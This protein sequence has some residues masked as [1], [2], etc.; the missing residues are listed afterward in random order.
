M[1]NDATRTKAVG[2]QIASGA[3]WLVLLRLTLRIIGFVSTA[4]LARLLVPADYGIV[5]MASSVLGALEALGT[6]GLILAL[7]R[8]QNADRSF[9]DTVWTITLAKGIITGAIIAGGAHLAATYLNEPRLEAV[10]YVLA[11]AVVIQGAE[12]VGVIEFRKDLQFDKEFQL[13][14]AGRLIAFV[15]TVGSAL[16]IWRSHWALIA[17]MV[18][19]TLTRFAMTYL[20]H[21]FRPRLSMAAW[22]KLFAFSLW[23]WLSNLASL[24]RSHGRTMVVA[25][26]LDSR[27]VGLFAVGQDIANLPTSELISAV[28]RVLYSGFAK[29]NDD[30]AALGRMVTQS[31][32]ILLLIHLPICLGLIL[33]ADPL[34]RIALGTQWLEVTPLI[35]ILAAA[36]LVGMPGPVTGMALVAAGLPHVDALRYIAYAVIE[37]PTLIMSLAYGGLAGGAWAIFAVALIEGVTALVIGGRYLHLSSRELARN[38]YRVVI[39]ATVMAGL[40]YLVGEQLGDATNLVEALIRLFVMS[41][42]GATI[43]AGLVLA[44]WMLSGRPESPE[45]QLLGLAYKRVGWLARIGPR[46]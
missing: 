29:V 32:N 43:Y 5:A 15:V 37:V 42:V 20:M 28:T 38:S 6:F 9:Y 3:A 34:V 8:Y 23:S 12:N 16:L 45:R 4:L 1:T 14:L 24:A 40:V 21:P 46:L 19:Q 30:P 13:L 10:L 7:I 22:R 25:S 31:L 2:A 27:Q 44:L 26:G 18:A 41:A 36:T 17:G 39:A 11:A 35:G 33:V